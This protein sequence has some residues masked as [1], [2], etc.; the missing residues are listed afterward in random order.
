M[1]NPYQSPLGEQFAN[2][3][4]QSL[5]ADRRNALAALQGPAISLIVVSVICVGLLAITLPFDI[6]LLATGGLGNLR[7][8]EAKAFQIVFRFIWGLVLMGASAYCIYG[9][10]QMKN[11]KN[12]QHAWA[13]AIVA[14][15]PCLGPCCVL[16]L[17]F[18]A[19]ALAVLARPEIRSRFET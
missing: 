3:A 10:W 5:D 11:L 19:W 18:G 4:R 17:P 16:G 6:L 7:V 1:S 14:V 2:L 13:A 12:F 8:D 15:I 9:A